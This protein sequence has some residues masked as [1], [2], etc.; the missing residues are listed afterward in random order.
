MIP[1][2]VRE[3]Y[4]RGPQ[5]LK[6]SKELLRAVGTKGFI[7]QLT[8][9]EKIGSAGLKREILAA[10]LIDSHL[11]SAK[12]SYVTR[13]IQCLAVSVVFGLLYL[14]AIQS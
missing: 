6:K 8:S 3:M 7:G 10:V 11:S 13:Y 1:R 14:V 9:R 2:D 5:T 4:D 12:Y